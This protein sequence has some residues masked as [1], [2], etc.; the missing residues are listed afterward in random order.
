MDKG[1]LRI[2]Y[3]DL[4]IRAKDLKDQNWKVTFFS[5]FLFALLLG[6]DAASILAGIDPA[7]MNFFKFLLVL[8]LVLGM[9]FGI[10]ILLITASELLRVKRRIL[11]CRNQFDEDVVEY[12]K[13]NGKFEKWYNQYNIIFQITIIVLTAILL[14]LHLFGTFN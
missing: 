9:E 13:D 12:L 5:V 4:T 7:K 11:I 2:C 3:S 6:L 10:N 14:L 1:N 8:I